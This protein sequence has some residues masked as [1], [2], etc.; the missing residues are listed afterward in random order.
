MCI[1]CLYH[2]N[3]VER[4]LWLLEGLRLLEKKEYHERECVKEKLIEKLMKKKID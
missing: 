1:S 4:R 3:V 2:Q